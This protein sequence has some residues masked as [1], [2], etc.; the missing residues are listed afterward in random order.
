MIDSVDISEVPDVRRALKCVIC[1]KANEGACIQVICINLHAHTAQCSHKQR[2]GEKTCCTAFHVTCALAARYEVSI[3]AEGPGVTT[4]SLC[5]RHAAK[6]KRTAR[7]R[8]EARRRARDRAREPSIERPH[9]LPNSLG[10][11]QR[12]SD[13]Q[14]VFRAYLATL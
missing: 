14:F 13:E 8:R 2:R 1:H 12:P 10:D 7:R 9:A 3:E 11:A 6:A 5:A 4:V